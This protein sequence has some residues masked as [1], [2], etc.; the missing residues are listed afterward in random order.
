[1]TDTRERTKTARNAGVELLRIAA[2]FMVVLLHMTSPILS[3]SDSPSSVF[4]LTWLLESACFCA[5]N[6]YGLISGY[7]GAGKSVSVGRAAAL[8]LR[9]EFY[10]VGL[11]L[12][13][14]A[15]RSPVSGDPLLWAL[16]P[17]TSGEYWYMSA[18]FGAMLLMPLLEA[19]VRNLSVR[20]LGLLSLGILVL[21]VSV[22]Y[23]APESS[24]FSI[25][26]VFSLA[27]GYSVV[28]LALLYVLGAFLRR[29]ELLKKVK[30]WQAAAL[31]LAALALTWSGALREDWR[32]VSYTSPTVLLEGA[33]LM[34]FFSKLELRSGFARRAVGTAA[35]AA[36]GVYLIHIHP[37]LYRA[38]TSRL[39]V[40][41]PDKGGVLC[42]TL[43]V[44]T[45]AAVYLAC[46]AVE[47]VRLKLF[48]LLRVNKLAAA[49]DRLIDRLPGGEKRGSGKEI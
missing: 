13:G 35:P 28:W 16:L 23:F 38:V 46:T 31:Y 40:S 12:L 34:L 20:S 21:S 15:I 24:G 4:E 10:S 22:T 30:K 26:G 1:M 6:C 36:L 41:F 47:L 8:W 5:V 39:T 17:I 32:T 45:G 7:V 48:E 42:V 27:E 18:Y 33:A 11:T 19:G 9:V 37:W 14:L 44:L 3:W 49:M 43:V 25:A 2:M 29:S